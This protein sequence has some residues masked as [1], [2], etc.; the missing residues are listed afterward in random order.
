VRLVNL[1]VA[2]GIVSL[3]IIN[4]DDCAVR[5]IGCSDCAL[6]FLFIKDSHQS[7]QAEHPHHSEGSNLCEIPD[8]TAR[9]IDLLSSRGIIRP[10]RFNSA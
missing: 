6:S 9:A 3:M 2:I 1:S 10:L 7:D 5:D 4:C 8:E